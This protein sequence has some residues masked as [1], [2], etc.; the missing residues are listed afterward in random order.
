MKKSDLKIGQ[1]VVW[2]NGT[3]QIYFPTS[4]VGIDLITINSSGEKRSGSLLSRWDDDFKDITHNQRLYDVVS[5]WDCGSSVISIFNDTSKVY[6][7]K[8]WERIEESEVEEITADE[9]M[10]RLEE[11]SG[12][13]VKII[14]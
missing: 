2:R 12:K 6:W 4:Y 10:K 3:E 9:A 7:N 13:K 11:Q 8:I 14:R 1:K 5:V